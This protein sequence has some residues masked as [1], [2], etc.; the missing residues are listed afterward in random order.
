[1]IINLCFEKV[2]ITDWKVLVCKLLL[3]LGRQE[4]GE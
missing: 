4:E 1:M 2:K 3:W